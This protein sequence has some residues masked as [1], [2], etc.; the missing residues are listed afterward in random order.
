M[1]SISEGA[2][3][4]AIP[5]HNN[6]GVVNRA[7]NNPVAA[8]YYPQD[9][10]AMVS[11]TATTPVSAASVAGDSRAY[12]QHPSNTTSDT[13]CSSPPDTP[14][15]KIMQQQHAVGVSEASASAP[16]QPTPPLSA[17]SHGANGQGDVH[18]ATAPWRAYHA[19]SYH[20]AIP[21]IPASYA[22]AGPFATGIDGAPLD[23]A[24]ND[25][26]YHGNSSHQQQHHPGF[27]TSATGG[28]PP[29]HSVPTQ[30]PAVTMSDMHHGNPQG[31]LGQG[32]GVA[33]FDPVAAAAAAANGG[34]MGEL[35]GGMYTGAHEI[36]SA[37]A[38]GMHL[39]PIDGPPGL[40]RQNSYFM[41]T[42]PPGNFD[43]MS[44]AAAAA[45]VAAVANGPYSPHIANGQ[46]AHYMNGRGPQTYPSPMM[47]GRFNLNMA[48]GAMPTPPPPQPPSAPPVMGSSSSQT[49]VRPVMGR[50][51][52]HHGG[53]SG[54]QTS[55]Q[56]KRYLCTV[57]QKM[58]ARPSTLATHM[59]SHTG[60]KPF[61]CT[62]D[63]CGKRFSVMSN[64]RRHQRIHERQ[65]SKFAD[66]HAQ[67][68]A[69]SARDDDSNSGST[70]PLASQLLHSSTP[71]A[72]HHMLP[73]PPMSASAS[74][75]GGPPPSLSA[76]AS[77][78]AP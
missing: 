23:H 5:P 69:T 56:R 21:T 58:F 47:L 66:M 41:A 28:P 49:P 14:L 48:H 16:A 54:G 53:S 60:E 42:S 39:P 34:Y 2:A 67:Q 35:G 70:T 4:H 37:P 20:Q 64:L 30:H 13:A 25:Y 11:W 45:A 26:H 77:F 18:S 63:G 31:A 73:P 72:H 7:H 59:H 8:A 12:Q 44:A 1:A 50:V 22:T 32:P 19:G 51:N 24:P 52:S 78:A 29:V 55:A 57:C 9:N 46:N 74:F 68:K 3:M 61:E 33:Q 75:A 62:W 17:S 71:V 43:P 15:V 10:G 76:S 36:A 65:R 6:P 40:G 27:S 38:T